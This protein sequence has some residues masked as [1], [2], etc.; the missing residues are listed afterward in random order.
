MT[1]LLHVHLKTKMKLIG[2]YQT[3]EE[4]KKGIMAN[5]LKF[6]EINYYGGNPVCIDAKGKPY[7]LTGALRTDVGTYITCS[8][9]EADV[10][11]LKSGG[12]NA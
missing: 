6:K 12:A 1:Y 4:V 5:D 11:S 10:Q 2:E 7:S 8:L 9:P 3:L